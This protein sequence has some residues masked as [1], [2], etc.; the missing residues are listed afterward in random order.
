MFAGIECDPRKNDGFILPQSGDLG[1]AAHVVAVGV[2]GDPFTIFQGS[3]FHINCGGSFRAF[4]VFLDAVFW[5]R[6]YKSVGIGAHGFVCFCIDDD[7]REIAKTPKLFHGLAEDGQLLSRQMKA[8]LLMF[9]LMSV[10]QAD[11]SVRTWTSRDGRTIEGRFVKGS[12][13]SVTVQRKDG[14]Q[15]E[16]ELKL[17]SESDVKYVRDLQARDE[18]EELRRVGMKSGP[19]AKHLTGAWE[20]M[21]AGDGLQFHFFAGKKLKAG[22]EYPLCIYLHGASNTGSGLS[23]REPERAALR[24]RGFMGIIQVSL[25]HRKLRLER[26]RSRKSRPGYLR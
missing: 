20:K 17:L 8:L 15:L 21:T 4:A 22:K 2:V 5:N 16:V 26:E 6:Y 18:G 13:D 11:E 25:L 10:L 1:E 12:K 23:K 19:Y 9:F 14:R 24:T 7:I 3:V